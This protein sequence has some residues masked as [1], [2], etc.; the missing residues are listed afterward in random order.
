MSIHKLTAGSGYDY[1]TRQV[2][3]MDATEKGHTGLTSYYLSWLNGLSALTVPTPEGVC[4]G[5]SADSLE[6]CAISPS[7][8]CKSKGLLPCRSTGQMFLIARDRSAGARV[9]LLHNA[10]RA[11][12][13]MESADPSAIPAQRAHAPAPWESQ[14]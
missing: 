2:A 5:Q 9:L 4:A 12:L 10:I 6:N 1:L 13:H 7:L 11:S 3:A 8:G 14:C